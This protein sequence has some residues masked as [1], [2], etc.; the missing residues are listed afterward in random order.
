MAEATPRLR[1]L[2][3][4]DVDRCLPDISARLDLA[5]QALRA[6]ATGTAEMP[7]KIGVHPRPGALLHAMPAWLRDSDL[8]G[9]KWIAAFP[10]NRSRGLPAISGLMVLNDAA[11]GVPTW[12]MDA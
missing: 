6:L 7:P 11:T 12:V 5:E 1:Y 4:A 2:S 8:V 9:L 3:A 10:D